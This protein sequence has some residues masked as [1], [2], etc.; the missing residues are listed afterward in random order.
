MQ[1]DSFHPKLPGDAAHRG[2]RLARRRHETLEAG[3]LGIWRLCLQTSG[4]Y[5]DSAIPCG[6]AKSKAG[7]AHC[8]RLRLMV[9]PR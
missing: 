8:V 5:R 4:I 1:P 2:L 9:W 6:L 7:A 3:F